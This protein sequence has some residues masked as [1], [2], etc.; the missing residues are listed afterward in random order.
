MVNLIKGI[1]VLL[2][3]GFVLFH[4]QAQEQFNPQI[5]YSIQ[6]DGE[7]WNGMSEAQKFWMVRGYL[8]GYYVW[9]HS[10]YSSQEHYV[11]VY[12]TLGALLYEDE[13]DLVVYANQYY[14]NRNHE[15]ILLIQG[16][17]HASPESKIPLDRR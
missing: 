6:M 10:F 1:L 9:A 15:Q 4:T 8:M 13:W 16:L 7:D 3:L 12:N 11:T 2:L 14:S 17:F 5:E